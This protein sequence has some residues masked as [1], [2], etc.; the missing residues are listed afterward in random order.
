[1]EAV[2]NKLEDKLFGK[3]LLFFASFRA[4]CKPEDSFL[5]LFL[6]PVFLGITTII[7]I[8]FQ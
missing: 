8:I 1:V 5:H 7:S 2:N 3:E 6:N 4:K